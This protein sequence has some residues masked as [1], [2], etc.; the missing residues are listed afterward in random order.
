MSDALSTTSEPVAQ[1]RRRGLSLGTQAKLLV[2]LLVVSLVSAIAIGVIGVTN[3]RASLQ[4]AAYDQLTTIRELRGEAL[5]SEFAAIQTAVEVDSRNAQTLA[6]LQAFDAGFD[7]LRDQPLDA[8][9]DAAL[10]AFYEERYI[11]AL[12]ERTGE[13][14]SA[15]AF[16]PATNAGRYIQSQYTATRGLEDF[17]AAL[18][19]HDAGD[20]SDW[21][22]ANAQYG[23]YLTGLVDTLGYED[24]L[25]LNLDAEVVYSAYQSVDMGLSM[26]GT[27]FGGSALTQAF[28]E[29]L[30]SGSLDA[31]ATT[32]FEA[33]LPSLGASTS[34]IVSPVGDGTNLVGALAV[35]VPSAQ[36]DAVLTGN[37]GWA[38]QGLGETGEVY[39]AGADGL[40]RSASRLLVEDPEGYVDQ[41]VSQG[42]PTRVAEQ[43]VADES[44]VLL[45]PVDDDGVEAALRGEDGVAEMADYRDGA[46]LVAYAPIELQGLDWVIV[47]R[48]D[49]D[50]AFA[51]VADFTRTVVLSILGLLL[52]VSIVSLLLAQVFTRPIN[53]LVTAVHQVAGGDYTVQ[54]PVRSRDEFGDLGTAFNEMAT[55]LRLKQDLIDQQQDENARLMRTLMPDSVAERLKDGGDEAIAERHENVSVLFAELVGWEDHARGLGLEEEM[56]QLNFLTRGFDEAATKAGVEQVRTLR[57]G[58]LASVGLQV[59]RVDNARRAVDFGIEMRAVVERFNA[60]HG[61]KVALRAGVDT[62][63]VTS[64]LV[65]RTNLAYDLWGDAVSLAYKVRTVTGEPGVYVSDAVHDR[66]RD[67]V[68]FTNVGS[69]DVA[70]TAKAVWRVG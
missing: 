44:T 55:S 69:V 2:M 52:L 68:E 43:V 38:D 21:S 57:G 60:Q 9:D 13:T 65:A 47:A 51:P 35:Q 6:A 26:R 24:L 8:A 22:A 7:A 23:P 40:M 10:T 59:P 49:A 29:V 31:L 48:I 54:V 17:D 33:Y 62:G 25:L 30:S 1:R 42:T 50:E 63:T 34:W 36:I 16:L 66:L 12:E 20:G 5:E 64:G 11:P 58:Y 3:G 61:T 56:G 28:D 37:E 19:D 4:A 39:V 67:T 15:D 70:G 53:K 27:V 14:Y 46:S 45:Q 41:V 32:D 18:Q